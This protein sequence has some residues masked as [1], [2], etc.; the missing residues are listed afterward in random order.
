MKRLLILSAL[1]PILSVRTLH[2]ETAACTAIAAVPFTITTPGI[3]C[4][5]QNLT[6]T[7]TG[8]AIV[9]LASN[10]V[11]DL[12]GFELEDTGEASWGGVLVAGSYNVV[13]NGTIHGFKTGVEIGHFSNCLIEKLLLT[14][15]DYGI[16]ATGSSRL[17]IRNNRIVNTGQ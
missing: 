10:V 13:R 11:L 17:T 9:I 5:R 12:N 6:M 1:L 2:A 4:L 7:T 14:E 8:P 15:C 16:E 3:Y